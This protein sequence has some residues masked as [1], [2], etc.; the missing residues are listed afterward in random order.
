MNDE[1]W[2]SG[3]MHI[4]R[5]PAEVRLILRAEELNVGPL[6]NATCRGPE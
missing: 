5:D 1:G 4:H 2:C 6:I 3:D